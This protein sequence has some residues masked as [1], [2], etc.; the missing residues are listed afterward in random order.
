MGGSGIAQL[1]LA[2][3]KGRISFTALPG[4]FVGSAIPT[5]GRVLCKSLVRLGA[6][7]A[8]RTFVLPA[9]AHDVPW[10][11]GEGLATQPTS[12]AASYVASCLSHVTRV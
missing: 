7:V 9:V 5:S 1:V 11:A 6:F 10:L 8:T 3:M 4:S 12:R 2:L